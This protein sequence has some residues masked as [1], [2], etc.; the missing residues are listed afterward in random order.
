MLFVL[1]KSY[2]FCCRRKAMMK[3][4]NDALHQSNATREEIYILLDRQ[5]Q[6]KIERMCHQDTGAKQTT[7]TIRSFSSRPKTSTFAF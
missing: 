3:Y 2:G 5:R 6:Q 7:H 4:L 1:L